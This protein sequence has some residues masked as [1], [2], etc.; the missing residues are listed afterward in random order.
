METPIPPQE[1]P[2]AHE[3]NHAP[4]AEPGLPL[5]PYSITAYT[6]GWDEGWVLEPARPTR[7][8]MDKIPHGFAYRCLPLVM[9]NQ[10]GWVIRCPVDFEA[11]WNGAAS[12]ENS[13]HFQFS[14]ER[15]KTM[16]SSHFG[17]GI[18]T[19]S[20]PWLFRTSPDLGLMVRGATNTLKFNAQPLDAFVETFWAPYTFTMNWK[21]IVPQVPI[22]F[23][24]G[25]PVC[26]LIPYPVALLEQVHCRKGDPAEIPEVIAQHNAWS[27]SRK[28]FNARQDRGPKEW[29]KTYYGGRYP[30]GTKTP[31]HWTSVRLETFDGPEA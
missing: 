20:L 18:F 27:E 2:P 25:D 31:H 22:F 7:N 17:H 9:G 13:I 24:K 1:F 3:V 14:D 19:F 28:A 4:A 10:F 6:I 26:Q 12:H 8:W 5:P 30:D 29:Q 11:V 21:I 16:I 23:K 15:Y